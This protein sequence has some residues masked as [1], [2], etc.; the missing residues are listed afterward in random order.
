MKLGDEV[1]VISSEEFDNYQIDDEG[2]VVW[3]GMPN[4][5]EAEIVRVKFTFGEWHVLKRELDVI[6]K[7]KIVCT[8]DFLMEYGDV[9]FIKGKT[10]E[11]TAV[12]G[13]FVGFS[14]VSMEHYMEA[15]D[16]ENLKERD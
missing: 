5:I 1:R 6:N 12:D 8:K 9:A 10:Y 7:M 2:T 16:L 15:E 13:S 4:T 11:F 14:E 3:V